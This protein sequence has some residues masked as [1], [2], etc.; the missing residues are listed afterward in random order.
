MYFQR[1]PVC[2]FKSR[3]NENFHTVYYRYRIIVIALVFIANKRKI[4]CLIRKTV[5]I[6]QLKKELLGERMQE[7][8]NLAAKAILVLLPQIFSCIKF[9]AFQQPK[10]IVLQ[11][12]VT[13]CLALN[14]FLGCNLNFHFYT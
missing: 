10:H 12:T 6:K 1:V 8:L 9:L 7:F 13:V 14:I 3:D 5:A 2:Y 11:S 4:C